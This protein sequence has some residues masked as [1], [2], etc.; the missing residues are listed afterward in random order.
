VNT[1]DTL[2]FNVTVTNVGSS[3]AYDINITP[4]LQNITPMNQCSFSISQLLPGESSNFTFNA[5]SVA[6]QWYTTVYVEYEN[7][8]GS[9]FLAGSNELEIKVDEATTYIDIEGD[10]IDEYANDLNNDTIYDA[11]VDPNNN[12]EVIEK[13]EF[14]FDNKPDFLIDTNN[15]TNAEIFYDP[16]DGFFT[17][18]VK[19]N[20]YN[21]SETQSLLAID[22]DTTLDLYYDSVR[23]IT[24]KLK[25]QNSTSYYIDTNGDGLYEVLY[26]LFTYDLLTS[27]FCS[28]GD[29]NCDGVIDHTDHLLFEQVYETT[30]S[31]LNYNNLADFDDNCNISFVDFVRFAR[32]YKE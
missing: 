26:D 23:N 27:K 15:D 4:D 8:N 17:G 12:S 18:I 10:Y 22:K 20:L 28:K 21:N 3:T 29:L 16:N 9:S 30:C 19:V 6:G 7:T 25:Q 31:N 13:K 24:T 32:R 14:N 5:T 11:Y 1:K 2:V